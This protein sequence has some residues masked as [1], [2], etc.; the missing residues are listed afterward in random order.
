MTN[1]YL[2]EYYLLNIIIERVGDSS[3]RYNLA[4]DF[5]KDVITAQPVNI[6]VNTTYK[7]WPIHGR[8]QSFHNRSREDFIRFR[9]RS[10]EQ[11]RWIINKINSFREKIAKTLSPQVMFYTCFYRIR[12]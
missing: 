1:H 2:Y 11:H 5:F 12:L 4:A 7:K 3:L 9:G 8:W 10:R 6:V